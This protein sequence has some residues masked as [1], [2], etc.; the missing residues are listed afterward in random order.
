MDEKGVL[1]CRAAAI[2]QEA[3]R[4]AIVRQ[5][6]EDGVLTRMSQDDSTHHTVRVCLGGGE[7][8]PAP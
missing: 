4:M 2:V 6:C 7:F 8:S 5:V 3:A 1:T